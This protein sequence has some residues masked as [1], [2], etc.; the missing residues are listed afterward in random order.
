MFNPGGCGRAE[1]KRAE[2]KRAFRKMGGDRGDAVGCI[3]GSWGEY[4]GPQSCTCQKPGEGLAA[5]QLQPSLFA[6]QWVRFSGSASYLTPATLAT[7]VHAVGASLNL[8]V[9]PHDSWTSGA[10]DRWWTAGC[11]DSSRQVRWAATAI[12]RSARLPSA[13]DVRHYPSFS[14][15]LVMIKTRKRNDVDTSNFFGDVGGW[16]CSFVDLDMLHVKW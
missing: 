7:H 8:S 10:M 13:P 3:E 9:S 1:Q 11:L 2:E 15:D 6:C 4:L 14:L 16:G 5:S 12:R